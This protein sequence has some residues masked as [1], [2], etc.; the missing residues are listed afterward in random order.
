MDLE[1]QMDRDGDE[2]DDRICVPGTLSVRPGEPM[3]SG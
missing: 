2:P 3:F 1:G